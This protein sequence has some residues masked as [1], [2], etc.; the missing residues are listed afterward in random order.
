MVNYNCAMKITM[1]SIGFVDTEAEKVP[2]FYSISDVRGRLIIED[3]YEAALRDIEK[4]DELLVVFCFHR[5]PSFAVEHLRV[6]PPS[7]GEERGVFSTRSPVRPNPVGVSEVV[8]RKVERNVL[9][10]S[11]LDMLDGSPILDIKPVK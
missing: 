1:E 11:G 3:K 9:H 6:T 7:R 10:V 8:V 2:R 5:S 4:G